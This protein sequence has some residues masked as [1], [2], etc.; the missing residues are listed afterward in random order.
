ML[1][2]FKRKGSTS[3]SS[4]VNV[5]LP[6]TN[7]AIPI[8]EN[9]GVPILENVGVPVSQTQFQRIDLDSLD[10]DLGTRKQIWEYHVNQRDE[11]RRAYIKKGSHQPPLETFKKSGKCNL[12]FQDFWYKNNS[13]WL[14]YSPTT[15]AAYCLPCFVFHNPNVVVG[16]NT[17]IVG[18]FRNWKKVGGKDCYFQGHIGKDPNSAHRVAEQMCKDL[19]NQSQHLQRVVDHF[20]T[21]QIANNRLQLKA[22]IFIF[23]Y[24]AF[25][26]IAFRGRD[27]SFSSLNHGNFHESLGIMTFW[28]EKVAEIIEKTPKNATYTSLRIQ[29]EILHVFSAK[30]KKAI[31]EEISDAKFCIMVDEARDES[32]KEQMVVV[33]RYVDAEGF[34]KEHFFGLIHVVDTA[35]L[36]LKKGIYSLL[37]QHCLDIQN[38]RGQGYDGASNM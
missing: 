36:T 37:S 11:I 32:M 33:F 22:T 34:V 29:K 2:F 10:Y 24:L 5:E 12:S 6:T 3:N 28:N 30:V 19:M 27:E 14:E 26:A 1:D 25:Q 18:G 38:I 7:D 23:R 17:F 15:D 8:L 35:A 20:T 13:K 16:Q 9:V 21:E 31:Q 4:E